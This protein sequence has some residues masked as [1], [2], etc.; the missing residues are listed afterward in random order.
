MEDHNE[1]FFLLALQYARGVG[2]LRAK[3]LIA[4]CGS[5]A[6][7]FSERPG[8]L[9]RIEGVGPFA[10]QRVLSPEN[11]RAAEKEIIAL[12]DRSIRV[13]T[14]LD[15]EYPERLRHCPDGPLLLFL[16][17]N[18]N[19]SSRRMISVVG[20]RRLTAWGRDFCEKF[21]DDLSPLRPTIVSGYAY[22]ADI[23]AHLAALDRGLQ[24]IA[25]VAHGLDITYPAAH[26]R[27]NERILE[28]G[29]F[30]SDFWLGVRPERDHFLRRNRIIAGL[31]EAVVVIESAE[32]GGSLVTADIANSYNREVFAVPGRPGDPF[33][34]GCN[35]LVKQ[36]K[37][38]L[39]ESAA[40]L[41][42]MLGW[43][44]DEKEVP[45]AVQKQLFVELEP[46]E[47]V[48][49]SVLGQKGKM[50]LDELAYSCNVPV[51]RLSATLLGME[52]K[53]VVKPLPGKY[54]E[55]T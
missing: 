15:K 28:Q 50:L 43:N 45:R 7:V 16:K 14:F 33:S 34:R 9:Q 55:L 1:L 13:V 41:A 25:C 18:A 17:G 37:A 20:T 2:D 30:L 40:D 12:S 35:M 11:L 46:A 32:K 47:E 19:L 22:G 51:N 4:A 26:K 8:V 48:V 21:I 6:A 29:G 52:M 27:Y 38:H 39:L 53:G 36:Q 3:K 31:S 44:P 54:F 23:C 42:F 49:F 10:V 24:T 5:A